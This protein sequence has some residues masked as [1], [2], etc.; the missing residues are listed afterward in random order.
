V[1]SIKDEAFRIC[2]A[3]NDQAF[4]ICETSDEGNGVTSIK[5]EAFRICEASN[6]Q[7][8]QICEASVEGNRV[9]SIKDDEE[10][11]N[12]GK[13]PDCVEDVTFI[14]NVWLTDLRSRSRL[15]HQ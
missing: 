10:P 1:T 11:P 6:D 3:S 2:E 13:S 12:H 9:A 4:R 7:A 8:F 5:D 15:I 14:L